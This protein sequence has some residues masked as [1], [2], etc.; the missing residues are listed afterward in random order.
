MFSARLTALDASGNVLGTVTET[1]LS[2]N[3]A[4][5]SAIF[6]GTGSDDT[7]ISKLVFTLDAASSPLGDFATNRLALAVP[8]PSSLALL[9]A[10]TVGPFAYAVRARRRSFVM[11]GK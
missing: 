6:I 2:I 3:A 1:G 7:P 11:G 10:G 9:A 8:E 5:N 4:D